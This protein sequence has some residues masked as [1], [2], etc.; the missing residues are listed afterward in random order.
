MIAA[1]RGGGLEGIGRPPRAARNG[2]PVLARLSMT[3]PYTLILLR[4]GNSEWN[5]KN[6]FTGWVDVV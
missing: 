6:L 1:D 4:H 2:H 3:E 5:Q